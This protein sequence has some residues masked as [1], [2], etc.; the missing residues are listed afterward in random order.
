MFQRFTNRIPQSTI[1]GAKIKTFYLDYIINEKTEKF[2]DCA[3][4]QLHKNMM[5]VSL[6]NPKLTHT[7]EKQMKKYQVVRTK[8]GM[9]FWKDHGSQ[10]ERLALP[11][12]TKQKNLLSKVFDPSDSLL[13]VKLCLHEGETHILVQDEKFYIKILEDKE[14]KL[15]VLGDYFVH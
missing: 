15:Q 1:A 3:I 8:T 10:I 2:E 12:D 13:V 9:L 6:K 5:A 7:I 11:L 14:S 4:L